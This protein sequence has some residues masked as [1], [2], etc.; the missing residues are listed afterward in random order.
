MKTK[1]H[2]LVAEALPSYEIGDELG[3]GGWGVV[4]AGHHRQLGRPVAIK[5]LPQAFSADE[6]VRARFLAEA[7][8]LASLTHPHIIPIYDYVEHEGLC[9]LVMEQ[10]TGGT[11]WSRF[12]EAGVTLQSACAAVMATCAAL[13]HAHEHDVL[14]RDVKPENVMFSD[15]GLLKVT[16]FGIAKVLSGSE[17]L[18]TRAGDILGTPAYMAPEQAVGGAIGPPADVYAAGVMLYELLSGRL[19][20]SEEGGALA[21]VYRHVNEEPVPITQQAPAMPAPLADVVMGALARSPDERFATAEAFGVALGEAATAVWGVGWL[22]RAELS[23]AAPGP[24]LASTMRATDSP[25]APPRQPPQAPDTIIGAVP[26]EL[27]T[28]AADTETGTGTADSGATDQAR[29]EPPAAPGTEPP[30]GAAPTTEPPNGAAPDTQTGEDAPRVRPEAAGHVA[31]AAAEGLDADELV[32]VRE[33]LQR[34]SSPVVQLVS[35]LALLLVTLGVAFAG[36]AAEQRDDDLSPGRLEIA[37]VDPATGR[38]PEVDLDEPVP[39]TVTGTDADALEIR[40]SVAGVPFGAER[41]EALE[42]EGDQASTLVR[43][44]GNRYLAASVVTAELRLLRGGDETAAYEFGVRNAQQPFLT[45]PGALVAALVL[46]AVAYAESFLRHLRRGRRRVS[47]VIGMLA[48]GA[49]GGMAA[50]GLAWLVG[51][52]QPVQFTAVAVAVL[53]AAAGL[54][55]AL[56]ALQAGKRRRL[57]RTRR[58]A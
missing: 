48:V 51:G 39:V 46:F 26:D 30:N 41:R 12:T 8:V 28:D 21:I 56:A 6:D 11:L 19:P 54:A 3:R 17:A 1:D 38:V 18:A 9:L 14:H 52:R 42:H 45:L 37:G 47:G 29:A 32:P 50:L 23:V 13:H 33:A 20:F 16:D 43:L 5:Q 31:G 57:Q 15:D 25:Q 7:R 58:A 10:L 35:A 22:E 55:A 44:Q 49:A 4:L 24:I 2:D 36:P 53:G 27:P 40:L 34:P